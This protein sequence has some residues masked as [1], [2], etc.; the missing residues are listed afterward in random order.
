MKLLVCGGRDFADRE[1]VFSCL[2]RVDRKRRVMLLVH[3][4]ATGADALADEWAAARGVARLPFPVPREEWR[5]LG[6]KAGPMRNARMLAIA[7]P[8]GVVAFP[9]GA[10]TADMVERAHRAGVPVWVPPY[11]GG[12]AA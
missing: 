12:V 6:P 11:P 10:G 9:G 2:D 7:A 5:A 1:F 3:G 8:D 4:G